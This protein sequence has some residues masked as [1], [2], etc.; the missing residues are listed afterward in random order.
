LNLSFI[1]ESIDF[2]LKTWIDYYTY[3]IKNHA[4]K[5]T[6]ICF[7][8]ICNFPEKT[9]S[10][11]SEIASLK[12]HLSTPEAYIPPTYNGVKKSDSTL[13]KNAVELYQLLNKKRKYT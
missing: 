1:K 11:I 5:I 9:Y 2:W 13:E 8:D 7:E 10:Y 4:D 6:L 12:Q 3:I